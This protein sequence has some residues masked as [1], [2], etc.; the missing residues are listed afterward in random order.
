MGFLKHLLGGMG[1]GGHH[2]R[3]HTRKHDYGNREIIQNKG[4]R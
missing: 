3:G 4:L 1:R 2:S